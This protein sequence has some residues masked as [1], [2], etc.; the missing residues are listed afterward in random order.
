MFL[1][2]DLLSSLPPSLPPSRPLFLSGISASI[3]PIGVDTRPDPLAIQV[4]EPHAVREGGREGGRE[5]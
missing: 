1:I 2:D 3:A 5:G 4:V